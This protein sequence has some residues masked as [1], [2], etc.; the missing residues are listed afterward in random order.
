LEPVVREN[1]RFYEAL[2]DL[3][4][5]D[6]ESANLPDAKTW[7]EKTLAVNPVHYPSCMLL[8]ELTRSKQY[9]SCIRKFSPKN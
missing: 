4:A 6:L 1:P 5:L 3:G 7:F 2:A 9:D 8:K